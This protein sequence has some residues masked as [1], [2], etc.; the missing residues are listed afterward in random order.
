[1]SF[2]TEIIHG[3]LAFSKDANLFLGGISMTDNKTKL[4]PAARRLVF[5][6]RV[7]GTILEEVMRQTIGCLK[8][9]DVKTKFK[10][11]S[12][13]IQL[14]RYGRDV[15]FYISREGHVTIE[16]KE[17]AHDNYVIQLFEYS[18]DEQQQEAFLSSMEKLTYEVIIT[19]LDKAGNDF[20]AYM[21]YVVNLNIPLFDAYDE[22]ISDIKDEWIC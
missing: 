8:T 3:I 21:D 7:Y 10:M 13:K 11:Y 17:F 1:M 22:M 6:D 4:T 9:V 20:H 15:M 12:R 14:H 2:L 5:N 19:F 18:E 16:L